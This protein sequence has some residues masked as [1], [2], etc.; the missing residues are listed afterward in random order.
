MDKL[1]RTLSNHIC[2]IINK[3]EIG[4]HE[5]ED[6][7]WWDLIETS[8]YPNKVAYNLVKA[9]VSKQPLINKV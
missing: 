7:I 1:S 5:K 9:N 3:I 6:Q 4:I 2:D 8:K